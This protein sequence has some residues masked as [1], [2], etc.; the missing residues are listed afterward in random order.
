MLY[1]GDS[2]EKQ[3]IGQIWKK[4]EIPFNHGKER[5]YSEYGQTGVSVLV[6]LCKT[7]IPFANLTRHNLQWPTIANSALSS[8]VG[9]V[10][11]QRCFPNPD[12]LWLWNKC[13]DFISANL[14][15]MK[16][17][18]HEIQSSASLYGITAWS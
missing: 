10:Y 2:K 5:S 9:L 7:L 14:R 18:W 17:K 15:G 3:T 8:A 6:N 16:P 13:I 4:Q 12:L 1:C 11:P